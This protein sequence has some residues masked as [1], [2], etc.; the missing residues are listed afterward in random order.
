V[1]RRSA[2]GNPAAVQRRLETLLANLEAAIAAG[3]LREQVRALV[4]VGFA[5]RDLGSSLLP[6]SEG[7]GKKR[8]LHYLRRYPSMP[9]SSDELRVVAGI[10]DWA[11]RVRELRVENGWQIVSGVTLS[12]MDEEDSKAILEEL[13]VDRIDDEEYVLLRDQPDEEAAE[14]W[15]SANQIRRTQGSTREK[16]LAFFLDNVGQTVTGEQ[17]RYVAGDEQTEW[18]RRTR[19][20][21]T[22]FGWPIATRTSGRPDLPVGV[23][24]LESDR[25]APEHDRTIP[26]STRRAVLM[27]DGYTCQRCG[28][29]HDSWNRSDPR[30]L[31]AHHVLAHVNGGTN[32]ASNLVTLCSACHDR[33]HSSDHTAGAFIAAEDAPN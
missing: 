29:T 11:R 24:V 31:E 13:G 16:L 9:V 8:I 18:A 26:D 20:L 28:W 21:R 4:P 25:Q 30:H 17:L 27:R 10:D 1:P 22:E 7:S 19:E 2:Q 33:V 3:E 14:R 23:Y 15:R 32:E 6:P 5:V 12:E